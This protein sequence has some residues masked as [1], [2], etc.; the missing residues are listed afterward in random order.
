MSSR[1]LW[2]VIRKEIQHIFRDR[3]TLI[4]VLITPTVLMLLMAY[5]LTVDIRHVPLAVLDQDRSALSRSFVQQITAGDLCA[6]RIT[7]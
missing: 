6:G 3:S 1:R 4:L 2:A 7:G 5:A